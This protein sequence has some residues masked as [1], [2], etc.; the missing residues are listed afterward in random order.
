MRARD[1]RVVERLDDV[2]VGALGEA[3][4]AGRRR[5]PRPLSTITGSAG[6]SAPSTPSDAADLAQDVEPGGVGEA[7]VEQQ[8]VRLVVAAEPQRV[9][10]ARAPAGRRSDRPR[11][12]RRAAPAWARRPRRRRP[13]RSRLAAA[14]S[15][16]KPSRRRLS[17]CGAGSSSTARCAAVLETEAPR[18]TARRIATRPAGR[19]RGRRGP[20]RTA[21]RRCGRCEQPGISRPAPARSR[22]RCAEAEEASAPAR[23]RPA[24]AGRGPRHRGSSRRRRGRILRCVRHDRRPTPRARPSP[25]T[26]CGRRAAPVQTAFRPA[27]DAHGSYASERFGP[28]GRPRTWVR[29]GRCQLSGKKATRR[30]NYESGSDYVL[31]YGELALLLQRGGLRVSASSRRR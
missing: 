26:G 29:S 12:G 5:L 11:G 21:S 31:E 19:S 7:E 6:R 3:P 13:W 1:L 25:P 28:S 10:R 17:P 14:A 18:G 2:V 23:S 24:R 16:S 8:Q 30:G 22:S 20:A 27:R 4:R 9:R 15:P